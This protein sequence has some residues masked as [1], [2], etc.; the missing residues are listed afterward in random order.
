MRSFRNG[1]SKKDLSMQTNALEFITTRPSHESSSNNILYRIEKN[2][3]ERNGD[4]SKQ[5][6]GAMCRRLVR[7]REHN[8]HNHHAKLNQAGP[9]L[10][11]K[12]E[13]ERSFKS[14]AS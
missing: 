14:R 6:R 11:R 9:Q 2:H 5:L 8:K 7:G 13:K 4:E 1:G 3:N 10:Q 12:Y